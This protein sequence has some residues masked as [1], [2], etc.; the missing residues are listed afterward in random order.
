MSDAGNL[1]ASDSADHEARQRLAQ[2]AGLRRKLAQHPE[3]REKSS[4]ALA[5]RASCS[6]L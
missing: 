5:K 1:I 6:A 2:V 4:K 3:T